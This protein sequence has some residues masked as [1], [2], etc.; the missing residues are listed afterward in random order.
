MSERKH[1]AEPWEYYKVDSQ[2]GVQASLKPVGEA[3]N[4]GYIVAQ[5]LGPDARRN[6][7]RTRSC[8]NALAGYSPEAVKEV[9]EWFKARNNV[10][11]EE[12]WP[13]SEYHESWNQLE[14]LFAKLDGEG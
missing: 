8:V 7:K 6:A 2:K 1:T 9:V 12:G 4:H 5:F 3:L 11:H 10:R 14:K 13:P